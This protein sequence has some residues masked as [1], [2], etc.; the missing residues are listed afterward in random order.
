MLVRQ[1][2]LS[3]ISAAQQL[4]A[5]GRHPACAERVYREILNQPAVSDNYS[6]T[7]LAAVV[8]LLVSSGRAPDASRML[9]S[10]L[11]T[12][13]AVPRF[14]YWLGSGEVPAFVDRA[15]GAA[16]FVDSLYA[17]NLGA[18]SPNSRWALA[19][20]GAG[21]RDTALVGRLERLA[22]TEAVGG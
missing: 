1:D 20:W 15:A 7:A 8:G 22:R 13:S 18:A 9:D 2:L 10:S 12:G 11:A 19:V 21:R 6:W 14:L 4:G 16:K 17:G 5:G 3:G